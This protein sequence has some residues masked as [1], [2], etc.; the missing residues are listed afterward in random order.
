MCSQADLTIRSH[1]DTSA[2]SRPS[3]PLVIG[4]GG[5]S[6]PMNRTNTYISRFADGFRSYLGCGSMAHLFQKCP[7]KNNEAIKYD[8]S[9]LE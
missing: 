8:F 9:R 3:R 6:Y 2:Q 5:K 4:K 1:T 7:E